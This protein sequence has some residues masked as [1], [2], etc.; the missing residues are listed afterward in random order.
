ME[1]E[2]SST[3]VVEKLTMDMVVAVNPAMVV[4]A[5]MQVDMVTVLLV[6]QEKTLIR[7]HHSQNW[8]SNAPP[9]P[10]PESE[11]DLKTFLGLRISSFEIKHPQWMLLPIYKDS[12]L[13][14][15]M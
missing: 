6:N 14:Q 1:E 5:V 11:F 10:S 2:T 4:D 7:E 15:Q 8:K 9:S 13:C 12:I 3:T